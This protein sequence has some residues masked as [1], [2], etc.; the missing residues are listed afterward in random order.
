MYHQTTPMQAEVYLDGEPVQ[1]PVSQSNTF[2]FDLGKAAEAQGLE[3][4][5][6][7]QPLNH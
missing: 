4:L 2:N 5:F 3:P 1:D 7:R 6:V